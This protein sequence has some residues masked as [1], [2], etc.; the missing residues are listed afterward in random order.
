MAFLADHGYKKIF[1]W[2]TKSYVI[3]S[4][5]YP[6]KGETSYTN[7]YHSHDEHDGRAKYASHIATLP[8]AIEDETPEED[9][10]VYLT[11]L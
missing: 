3:Y 6:N 7:I 2:T 1:Y 4:H 11:F 5:A 9:I 8:F 10:N